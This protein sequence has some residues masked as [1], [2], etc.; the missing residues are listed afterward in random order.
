MSICAPLSA[1]DVQ[2]LHPPTGQSVDAVLGMRCCQRHPWR[3]TSVGAPYGA[4]DH[5]VCHRDNDPASWHLIQPEAGPFV[6]QSV[7]FA[8]GNHEIPFVSLSSLPLSRIQPIDL[9]WS[10]CL[11]LAHVVL[12]QQVGS[13]YAILSQVELLTKDARRVKC[14]PEGAAQNVYIRVWPQDGSQVEPYRMRLGEPPWGERRVGMALMATLPIPFGLPMSNEIDHKVNVHQ[15][16]SPWQGPVPPIQ[17]ALPVSAP[18][19]PPNI[20]L[21]CAAASSRASSVY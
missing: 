2:L 18:Q 4:A 5:L 19:A 9:I 11:P 10:E 20:E 15:V 7:T 3:Q 12:S 21:S 14:A 6:E 13:D 17:S 1:R 16:P 8:T